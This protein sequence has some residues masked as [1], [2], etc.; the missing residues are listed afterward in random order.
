MMNSFARN[1]I[2][3]TPSYLSIH[4]HYYRSPAIIFSSIFSL[5]SSNADCCTYI[6]IRLALMHQSTSSPR[7]PTTSKLVVEASK[8][9]QNSHRSFQISPEHSSS[10]LLPNESLGELCFSFSC[11]TLVKLF[12]SLQSP[13][14]PVL[15]LCSALIFDMLTTE[16]SLVLMLQTFLSTA[17]IQIFLAFIY[18]RSTEY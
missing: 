6:F 18:Y 8:S 7:P 17:T 9:L 3:P 1:S 2:N 11:R 4:L 13:V 15:L 16:L 5:S 14:L 12:S 10:P